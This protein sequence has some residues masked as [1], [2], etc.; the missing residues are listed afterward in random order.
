MNYEVLKIII[1]A[2]QIGGFGMGGEYTKPDLILEH[3]SKMA[4]ESLRIQRDC[5]K[6]LIK[7]MKF[8]WELLSI[9]DC[10]LKK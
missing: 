9:E 7:C 8:N 10:L 4:I 5:Q 6:K 3:Q 1:A 2:C